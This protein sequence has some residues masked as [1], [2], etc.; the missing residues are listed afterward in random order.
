MNAAEPLTVR[1]PFV[2]TAITEKFGKAI[3]EQY[4]SNG[5]LVLM[6]DPA[7]NVELCTFLKITEGLEYNMMLDLCGVDYPSRKERFEVVV[8]LHSMKYQHRIRLRFPI[9]GAEPKIR[10]LSDVWL[11]A[12]WAEREAFDF[13]GI[14]FVGHPD[15]RRI[16]NPDDFEG[17]PLRK[18]FPTRGLKRGSFPLGRVINNKRTE[19]PDFYSE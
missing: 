16:L 17:H 13:F 10:S 15:L 5:M 11:A 14:D 8:H 18:D 3:V 9:L 7:V 2:I 4:E 19:T 1:N 6:C 12:D